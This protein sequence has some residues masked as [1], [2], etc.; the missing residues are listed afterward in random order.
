MRVL[1]C[2]LVDS[3]DSVD[4]RTCG[5]VDSVGLWAC[6]PVDSVELWTFALEATD[7]STNSIIA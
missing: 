2:G 3:M 7:L 1:T 5:P 6:G 4:L